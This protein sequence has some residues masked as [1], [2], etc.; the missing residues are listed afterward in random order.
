M[1]KRIL[2]SVLSVVAASGQGVVAGHVTLSVEEYN[3]LL[4]MAAKQPKRP[5]GPPVPYAVHDASLKLRVEGESV[6]GAV[7]LHGEVLEKRDIKAPLVTGMTV[8]DARQNGRPLPLV[9]E[10]GTHA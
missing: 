9:K 7:E 5:E 3:R 1:T 8:L 6:V 2:V 10:G 4:E